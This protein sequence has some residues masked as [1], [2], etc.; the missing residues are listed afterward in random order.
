MDFEAIPDSKSEIER[1]IVRI[2]NLKYRLQFFKDSQQHDFKGFEYDGA[3]ENEDS[4]VNYVAETSI[5]SVDTFIQAYVE[6]MEILSA[7]QQRCLS[8]LKQL[9]IIC[10]FKN[11]DELKTELLKC[12]V[13]L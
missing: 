5:D 11:L 8:R 10:G 9:D 1:S 7:A 13:E 4:G 12:E 6:N 2:D 3:E